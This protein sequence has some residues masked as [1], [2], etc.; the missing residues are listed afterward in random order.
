MKHYCSS[1]SR[2]STINTVEEFAR[3]SRW[4]SIAVALEDQRQCSIQ[5]GCLIWRNCLECSHE[6]RT[7]QEPA[8]HDNASEVYAATSSPDEN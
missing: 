4:V 3:Y 2:I 6:Q 1:K 8:E 5:G 7:M